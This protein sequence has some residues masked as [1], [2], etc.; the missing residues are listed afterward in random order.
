MAW[1]TPANTCETSAEVPSK[2]GAADIRFS[3][4]VTEFGGKI[5]SNPA[6]HHMHVRSLRV[7]SHEK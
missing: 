2:Q 4:A 7:F 5:P 6:G 1:N 3:T